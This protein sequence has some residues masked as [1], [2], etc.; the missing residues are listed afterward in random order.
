M[1]DETKDTQDSEDTT[2]TSDT[3]GMTSSDNVTAEGSGDGEDLAAAW[4]QALETED[5]GLDNLEFP[6][7]M[8]EDKVLSQNEIDSLLG[9]TDGGG[10]GSND[11]I[12]SILNSG[13]LHYERLP[14]LEVV[15]DRL[16]R[17]LTTSLRNFTSENV[18]VS[19]ESFVS[20]RFGDYLNS[21]P[22]PALLTIFKARQWNDF[23]LITTD[24][25]LI[26]SIVDVLLGGRKGNALMR[27]EGRPYTTIERKLAQ[28]LVELILSDLEQSFTPLCPI[29][30]DFD[31]LETNPV[32]AAIARPGNAAI[33]A[34]L[35]VDMDDRGGKIDFLIPYSTVEPIRDLLLQTFM[36]EKFGQD[37]I[38]ENHLANQLWSTDFTLEATLDE[39]TL[40]LGEILNLQVGSQIILTVNP[41]SK[42]QLKCGD[43][44]LFNGSMGRKGQNKAIKIDEEFLSH[45]QQSMQGASS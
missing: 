31:R 13:N 44:V 19:L 8:G 43:Q 16:V 6:E 33:V 14:M 36:G 42:A 4:E 2:G 18:E 37:S 10:G 35:R 20:I 15:F 25:S 3:E 29:N 28:R 7:S 26:Y 22:L 17:L 45:I 40:P 41:E 23:G 5:N 12:F 21:I 1:I 11:G 9:I 32:F 27:I 24:S 30:F 38:W 34:R 39:I